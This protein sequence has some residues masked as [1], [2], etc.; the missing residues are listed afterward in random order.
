MARREAIFCDIVETWGGPC[1]HVRSRVCPLCLRD[2]CYMHMREGKVR[3]SGQIFVVDESRNTATP[4]QPAVFSRRDADTNS[5]IC[6]DCFDAIASHDDIARRVQGA[7]KELVT[8]F[9][10]NLVET[11]REA[12]S[13]ARAEAALLKD[14][15]K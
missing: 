8:Q 11:I 12:L 1:Q 14:K 10:T 7:M 5:P 2:V 3:L 4:G 9:H 13:A 15:P 6:G